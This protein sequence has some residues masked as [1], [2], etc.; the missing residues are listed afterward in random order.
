M[1][2]SAVDINGDG[3]ISKQEL[4]SA[5]KNTEGCK[6]IEVCTFTHRNRPFPWQP[7]A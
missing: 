1:L 7:E 5:F 4:E 2:F 3:A 6:A